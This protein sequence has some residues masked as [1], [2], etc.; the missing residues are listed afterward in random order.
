MMRGIKAQFMVVSWTL[1]FRVS[2]AGSFHYLKK[3]TA[4]LLRAPEVVGR[5]GPV[6]I[7]LGCGNE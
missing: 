7:A 4:V 3:I 5:P 6:M 2:C 1:I